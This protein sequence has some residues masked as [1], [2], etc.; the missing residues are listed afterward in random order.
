MV[1]VGVWQN[2]EFGGYTDFPESCSIRTVAGK[3]IAAGYLLRYANH[4]TI[5][6]YKSNGVEILVEEKDS[7]YIETLSRLSYQM[8][9]S[10]ALPSIDTTGRY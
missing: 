1:R 2:G 10:A 3:Y 6:L 4:V 7:E 9:A 8:E 5:S